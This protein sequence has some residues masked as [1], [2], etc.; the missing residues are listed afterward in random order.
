[1]KL[2][3]MELGE[4]VYVTMFM[5]AVKDKVIYWYR[6]MGFVLRITDYFIYKLI[7]DFNV[8]FQN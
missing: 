8:E 2:I 7:E 5:S 4:A 1:M 3:N 6:I